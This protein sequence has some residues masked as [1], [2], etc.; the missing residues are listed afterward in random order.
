MTH[1][2]PTLET[3][4]MVIG[5][6]TAHT[7]SRAWLRPRSGVVKFGQVVGCGAVRAA[8]RPN[9]GRGGPVCQR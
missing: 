4:L 3:S 8:F 5:G 9:A 6:E 1:A 7:E 2:P